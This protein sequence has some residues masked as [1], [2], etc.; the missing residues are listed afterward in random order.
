MALIA[1]DEMPQSLELSAKSATA[2][3]QADLEA[4]LVL[5]QSQWE[6]VGKEDR[7]DTA[8]PEK[9]RQQ[10]NRIKKALITL[11]QG[12]PEELPLELPAAAPLVAAG[13][14]EGRFKWQ[15]LV[16]MLLVKGWI[17][18]WILLYK[19]TGG[20]TSGES[21]ATIALLLPSFAAYISPMLTDL[22]RQRNRPSLPAALEPRVPR[23]MQW[24]TFG[25]VLAY[26]MILHSIINDK[27]AGQ[28]ADDSAANFESLTK[29]LALVESGLGVYIALVVGEFFKKNKP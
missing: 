2:L 19:R 13:V 9:I 29:W 11:V 12:M 26:G 25:L 18:Y 28:L 20:F 4:E 10:R 24:L 16:L 1:S 17:V 23:S 8:D 27:A 22:L 14:T 15:L 7:S 3:G 6:Q 21:Q 5:L